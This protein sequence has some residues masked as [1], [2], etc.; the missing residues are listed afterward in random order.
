MTEDL[1]A[2]MR[3]GDR[4]ALARFLDAH[5]A[6]L[7]ALMEALDPTQSR[8]GHRALAHAVWKASLTALPRVDGLGHVLAV[9]SA[10]LAA[11]LPPGVPN[12]RPARAAFVRAVAAQHLGIG[13][14]GEL[15]L[16]RDALAEAPE[17]EALKARLEAALDAA[18]AARP[19]APSRFAAVWSEVVPD[20]D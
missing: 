9:T 3:R 14:G 12:P 2:A 6:A 10:S 4:D 7:E 16:I 13:L 17:L 5:G 18:Q 19:H 20:L 8:G 15:A 1:L 11:G